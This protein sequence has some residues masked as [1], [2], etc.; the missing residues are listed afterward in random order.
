MKAKKSTPGNAS[1]DTNSQRPLCPI[2]SVELSSL[3]NLKLTNNYEL[4][5]C[6]RGQHTCREV[7]GK[8]IVKP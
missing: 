3:G 1:A 2:H 5:W 4:Y 7:N 6:N 8:L